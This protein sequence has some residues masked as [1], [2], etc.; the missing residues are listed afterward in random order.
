MLLM[1]RDVTYRE[2]SMAQ[3]TQS[4]AIRY[5]SARGDEGRYYIVIQHV[6]TVV[7]RHGEYDVVMTTAVYD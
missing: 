7:R 1:E 5:S 2:A 3:P 6:G 4:A